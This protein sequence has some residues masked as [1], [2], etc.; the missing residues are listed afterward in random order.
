MGHEIILVNLAWCLSPKQSVVRVID[1][2]ARTQRSVRGSPNALLWEEKFLL[3]HTQEESTP[4]RI[5][6]HTEIIYFSTLPD[7][8]GGSLN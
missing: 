5:G 1:S 8:N 7:K 3:L 2:L 6:R 4:F